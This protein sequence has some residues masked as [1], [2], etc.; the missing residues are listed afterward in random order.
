MRTSVRFLGVL[1]LGLSS[2]GLSASEPSPPASGKSGEAEYHHRRGGF[3]HRFQQ[4]RHRKEAM[5][6]MAYHLKL[7]DQQKAQI[8]DLRLKNLDSIKAGRTAAMDARKAYALAAQ[9]PATP[10][11]KLKALHQDAADKRFEVLLAQRAVRAQMREVLSPAQRTEMDRM[12]VLASDHRAFRATRMQMNMEGHHRP[13][14]AHARFQQGPDPQ[15]AE[16]P[17]TKG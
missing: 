17:G 4:V 14:W 9:D 1:I 15:G 13:G 2:L 12:K 8:K 16:K 11:E 7:T 3:G 6:F 5:A 10:V